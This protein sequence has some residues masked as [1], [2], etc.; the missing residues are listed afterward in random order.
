MTELVLTPALRDKVDSTLG[1]A[2]ALANAARSLTISND[3][4][5]QLA[6]EFVARVARIKKDNETA[7]QA[8]V[9][10]LIDRKTAIDAAFKEPVALLEEADAVVRRALLGY[11]REQERLRLVEAMR[12]DAE[13]RAAEA[14]AEAERRRLAE[15]AARVEREAA[16]AEQRRQVE[17][18][19]AQDVLAQRVA[20]MGEDELREIVRAEGDGDVDLRDAASAELSLREGRRAN[21]ARVEAAQAAAAAAHVAEL[22]AKS[23]DVVPLAPAAPMRAMS[24]SATTTKR[25][26]GTVVDESRVPREYLAV[27]QRKINAAVKAGVRD[28]PG[29]TIE[30]VDGLSVRTAS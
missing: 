18:E 13:R 8:E 14:A 9:R 30:Q 19:A 1:Q 25:W 22:Q 26:V 23:A 4:E 6:T 29:V 15:E 20:V 3:T 28:I 10:P 16:E 21:Q 12:V 27:D 2:H 5:A 24:G 17:L 11:H 7:R